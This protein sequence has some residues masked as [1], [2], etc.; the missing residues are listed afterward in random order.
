MG[1]D[2]QS[3]EAMHCHLAHKRNTSGLCLV[4]IMI[5]LA[6]SSSVWRHRNKCSEKDLTQHVNCD[7]DHIRLP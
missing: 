1:C 3:T 5:C 2:G 4:L 7:G 6:D